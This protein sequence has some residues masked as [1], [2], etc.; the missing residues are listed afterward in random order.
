V[1][2]SGWVKRGI[3]LEVLALHHATVNR[4]RHFAMRLN[5]SPLVFDNLHAGTAV[6]LMEIRQSRERIEALTKMRGQRKMAIVHKAG[7]LLARAGCLGVLFAIA[8]ALGAAS[9]PQSTAITITL[10]GQSMIRSDIRATSPASAPVIQGLL[11]GDVVFTNLEAAVA[12]KGETVQE[13]RR[14][15]HADIHR[16]TDELGERRRV[17][18]ISGEETA[19]DFVAAD[20]VEPHWRGRARHSQ[21]SRQQPVPR[22]LRFALARVG[23]QSGLYPPAPGRRVK[24]LRHHSGN[25]R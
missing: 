7:R 15:A 25:R 16:R 10:A 23:C 24:T 12:E 19:I 18:P 13:G 14:T 2:T 20:R 17:R 9:R 4:F 1:I 21:P 6:S 22:H 11:K 3:V 8:C 5:T